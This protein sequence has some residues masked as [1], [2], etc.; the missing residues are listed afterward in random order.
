MDMNNIKV[1]YKQELDKIM[2]TFVKDTHFSIN[3]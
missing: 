3:M 1:C 2:D